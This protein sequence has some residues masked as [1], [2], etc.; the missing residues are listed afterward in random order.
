VHYSL[1]GTTEQYREKVYGDNWQGQ[2][3]PD[4]YGTEEDHDAWDLRA[5]YDELWDMYSDAV[6]DYQI[7]HESVA[8]LLHSSSSVDYVISTIPAPSLCAVPRQHAF[9]GQEVWAAGE[10]TSGKRT[11]GKHSF[12]FNCAPETIV[13]NGERAPSWYRMARIFGH[14]TVEWPMQPSYSGAVP[15]VKPLSHTC[16]CFPQ[17]LRVGR[18]GAWQKGVLVHQVFDQVAD[19]VGHVGSIKP[20]LQA[21]KRAI[22]G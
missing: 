10:R 6:V 15:V 20:R 13:C 7:S 4:E 22:L 8:A 18:Y 1:L 2:V 9:T 21:V 17:V 19:A 14:T 3:S 11:S 5:T 12:P 16:D